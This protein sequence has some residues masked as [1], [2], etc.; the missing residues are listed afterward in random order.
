MADIL[1]AN[2]VKAYEFNR[3]ITDIYGEDAII[4]ETRQKLARKFKEIQ[5]EQGQLAV[6]W[7]VYLDAIT[8]KRNFNTGDKHKYKHRHWDHV[9]LYPWG[10]VPV[11]FW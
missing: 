2:H 11:T 8:K 1:N 4:D 3:Q 9:E 7:R 10:K 5:T 6:V